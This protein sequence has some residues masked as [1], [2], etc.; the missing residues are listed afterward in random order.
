MAFT[1]HHY[2][3]KDGNNLCLSLKSLYGFGL[4]KAKKVSAL[5]GTH[6][7][8]TKLKYIQSS[9]G[10]E[11]LDLLTNI[12]KI[13]TIDYPLRLSIFNRIQLLKSIDSYRG[14]RHIQGLPIHGQRTH[15]N[16]N[17]IRKLRKMGKLSPINQPTVIVDKPK[18]KMSKGKNDNKKNKTK[19][20][21]P[22]KSKGG[23]GDKKKKK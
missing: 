16:S 17:T 19:Q 2:S 8:K 10:R 14:I 21:P 6:F 5:L 7:D 4:R 3:I 9:A 20:L 15:T 1:V 18:G 13:V 22:P 11:E 23:K 12:L